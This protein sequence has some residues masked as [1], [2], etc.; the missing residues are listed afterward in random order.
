MELKASLEKID[1]PSEVKQEFSPKE[2]K[3]SKQ[4]IQNDE[5]ELSEVK[6]FESECFVE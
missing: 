4:Q 5:E 6:N 3:V 1:L 2:I